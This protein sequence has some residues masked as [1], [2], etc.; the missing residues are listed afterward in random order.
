MSSGQILAAAAPPSKRRSTIFFVPRAAGPP[1]FLWLSLLFG[2]LVLLDLGLF[3]WLIFRSLSQR[4]VER[5]LLETR[6]RARDVAAELER[7]ASERGADLEALALERETQT[8]INSVLA[9]RE[10]FDTVEVRDRDGRLV[11]RADSEVTFYLRDPATL[12]PAAGDVPPDIERRSTE[13]QATYDVEVPIG[14]LGYLQIGVSRGELESRIAVL[15][16]ELTGRIAFTGLVTLL[17]LALAYLAI[18]LLWRRGRRLAVQAEEAERLAYVG[19]VASGLAHEIRNPLNAL[20]LNLQ[21]LE[22]EMGAGRNRRLFAVTREEIGRLERL[23]TDFLRYARPRPLERAPLPAASLLERAREVVA[24]EARARGVELA[25]E[26]ASGGAWLEADAGQMGQLLLNLLHNALA[27]TEGA[28]RPPRVVLR[29]AR[30]GGRLALEVVDNGRG[31]AAQERERIFDL[32][33]STRRGGT[34]LGLAVVASIAR[35]HGAELVVESE[36][37]AGATFRV[38][39]PLA[40]GPGMRGQEVPGR[41]LEAPAVSGTETAGT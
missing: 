23:V 32:F 40:A 29:A 19:T 15:R 16:R 20:N 12:A 11:L 31:I 10:V 26:D 38:L 9:Q 37:G 13:R 5:V 14:E 27:A 18:G 17:L 41:A 28:G 21:L 2:L 8:F 4:E 30:A 35:A 25:V 7:G 1:R 3:G 36:P 33:Y 6:E 22:E 24:A 39:L 34:G